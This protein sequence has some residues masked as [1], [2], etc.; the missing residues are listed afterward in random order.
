MKKVKCGGTKKFRLRK[1]LQ[2]QYLIF[3]SVKVGFYI[4]G[5]DIFKT[6]KIKKPDSFIERDPVQ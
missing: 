4:S 3:S 6:P 5:N 2:N 1:S